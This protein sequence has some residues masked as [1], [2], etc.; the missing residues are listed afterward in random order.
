VPDHRIR[1]GA[2]LFDRVGDPNPALAVR[3]I[4]EPSGASPAGMDLRFHHEH[5]AGEFFGRRD[6]LIRRPRHEPIRNRHV[7][8]LEQFLGLV[9]VDVHRTNR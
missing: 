3:I 2:D 1:V 8:T 6:R 9:L 5:R 7:V 4:R